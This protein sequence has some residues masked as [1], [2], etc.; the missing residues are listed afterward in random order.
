M[1]D[2]RAANG[3]LLFVYGTLMHAT[4]GNEMA[5]LLR[6]NS[7]HLGAAQMQGKLYRVEHRYPGVTD[8][9]DP[10]DVVHGDL[11]RLGE[12]AGEVIAALDLYED[13]GGGFSEPYEY[14]REMRQIRSIDGTVTAWVYIYNWPI[15]EATRIKSGR[16]IP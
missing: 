2:L 3:D 16:F 12:N 5:D 15:D 4:S 6:N 7:E 9:D 1:T 13:I 11:F 10:N 8:S 14:R